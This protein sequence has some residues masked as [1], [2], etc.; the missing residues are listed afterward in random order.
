M[1]Y[2][3]IKCKIDPCH[4]YNEC[5]FNKLTEDERKNNLPY[6]VNCKKENYRE[7]EKYKQ[8]I[9]SIK[10]KLE[11]RRDQAVSRQQSFDNYITPGISFTIISNPSLSITVDTPPSLNHTSDINNIMLVLGQLVKTVN[12]LVEAIKIDKIH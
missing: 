7:C 12:Q 1:P 8:I 6:W 5:P 9:K 11:Q 2:R 4:S 10:L 3:C